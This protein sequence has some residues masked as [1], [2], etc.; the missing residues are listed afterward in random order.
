MCRGSEISVDALLLYAARRSVEAVASSDGRATA[1]LATLREFQQ[2][3]RPWVARGPRPRP[4][5]WLSSGA[6]G[7][8]MWG[9]PHY[10]CA[11]ATKRQGNLT[12]VC[13]LRVAMLWGRL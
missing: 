8:G 7:R 3:A 1:L 5:P 13:E 10:T 12:C 2:L 6:C 9:G 4:R 11:S